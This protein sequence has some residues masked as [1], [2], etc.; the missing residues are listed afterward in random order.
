[1]FTFPSL[2]AVIM[3]V[4]WQREIEVA[5]GTE[6]FSQRADYS[7]SLKVEDGGPERW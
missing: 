2:E 4:T 5:D 3:Y 6:V 1:M 7:G